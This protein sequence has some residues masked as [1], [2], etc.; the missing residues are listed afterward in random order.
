MSDPTAEPKGMTGEQWLQM[1]KDTVDEVIQ[2]NEPYAAYA[3]IVALES[4]M[5]QALLYVRRKRMQLANKH[6]FR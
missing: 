1:I 6:R 4:T 2:D 3:G 5:N